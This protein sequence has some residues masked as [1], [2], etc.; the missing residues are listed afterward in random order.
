ME[1]DAVPEA[2]NL[3]LPSSLS[4]LSDSEKKNIEKEDVKSKEDDEDKDEEKEERGGLLTHLISSLV[5][6]RSPKTGKVFDKKLEIENEDSK[7]FDDL[8]SNSNGK[9]QN[10]NEGVLNN[11]VSNL[12]KNNKNQET[13]GMEDNE[14]RKRLKTEKEGERGGGII[15][16]IVSHFPSYITGISSLLFTKDYFIS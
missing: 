3:L 7:A 5:S 11:M 2:E 16:N 8:V 13:D 9:G 4:P 15:D 12:F 10:Q 6:P 1:D 14:A